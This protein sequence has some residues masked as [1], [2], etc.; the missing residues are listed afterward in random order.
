MKSFACVQFMHIIQRRH[1]NY[2]VVW[3]NGVNF[4]TRKFWGNHQC[5]SV[6]IP[7]E[8]RSVSVQ[9]AFSVIHRNGN[10]YAQCLVWVSHGSDIPRSLW[11]SCFNSFYGQT[12]ELL[13]HRTELKTDFYCTILQ[14]MNGAKVYWEHQTLDSD[15]FYAKIYWLLY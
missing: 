3:E 8:C 4:N 12:L 6:F 9:T 13:N 11:G 15:I 2:I 7:L 5:T 1:K 14:D 10:S